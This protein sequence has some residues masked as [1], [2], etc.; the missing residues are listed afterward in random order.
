MTFEE[1][2]IEIAVN[3]KMRLAQLYIPSQKASEKP[4]SGITIQNKSAYF[5]I[6]DCAKLA[7]E[8]LPLAVYLE[9]SPSELNGKV[10]EKMIEDFVNFTYAEKFN[11]SSALLNNI[12][13]NINSTATQEI[14]PITNITIT[15]PSSYDNVYGDYGNDAISPTPPTTIPSIDYKNK[16]DIIKRLKEYFKCKE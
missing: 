15:P 13:I 1:K 3:K 8:F 9:L 12:I 7:H 6:Q 14:T 11:F 4:D 10:T 5:V 16:D 2:I